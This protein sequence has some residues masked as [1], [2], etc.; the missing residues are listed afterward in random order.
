[1]NQTSKVL[2]SPLMRK[3]KGFLQLEYKFSPA[4][5]G[6]FEVLM[7]KE[8]RGE[9][10]MDEAL[11]GKVLRGKAWENKRKPRFTLL[12]FQQHWGRASVSP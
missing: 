4:P 2:F 5:E 8:L 9:V 3:S 7:G 6:G 1:M 12:Q 11:M 10:L